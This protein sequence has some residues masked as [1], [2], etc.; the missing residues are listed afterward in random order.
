MGVAE[1]LL[2]R[3]ALLLGRRH[4][5]GRR[6]ILDAETGTAVGF[7]QHRPRAG[8]RARFTRR[9]VEVREQEDDSLLFV[10]RRCWS[11]FAWF[12]VSDADDAL[13]GWHGLS[14]LLDR[15]G[16]RVA[17]REDEAET[18]TSWFNGSDGRVLARLAPQGDDV[19]LTFADEVTEEPFV[20]MLLLAAALRW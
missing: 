8:W 14:M 1:G 3:K 4:E 11:L 17:L 7:R 18:G 9:V 20:K 13:V 10:V 19:R 16:R 15:T 5:S 6:V 12:E 2:E